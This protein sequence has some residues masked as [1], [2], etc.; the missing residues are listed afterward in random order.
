LQQRLSG[1]VARASRRSKQRAIRTIHRNRHTLLLRLNTMH[2]RVVLVGLCLWLVSCSKIADSGDALVS[3]GGASTSGGMPATGG[4][5]G[6]VTTG[7][8][9]DLSL[10]GGM[11]DGGAPSE[12][13]L[14]RC[15]DCSY[16]ACSDGKTTSISGTVRTPAK[17]DPDPLYNAVVFVPGEELTPFSAGVTCD[18][19]GNVSGK[20]LAA[21][22]SGSDGTFKL[23]DVPAGHDIPLVV[24]MGRWRRQV[25][26]P[27]IVA[28]QDNALPAELTRFPRN[29]T[30]GDIPHM[31]IVTSVYDPEEC[32]LRKI[33]IEDTELTNQSGD[34]R[35]HLFKGMG[36][37]PPL[38][39]G[40]VEADALWGDP[41]ALLRYDMVLLPCGSAPEYVN[42]GRGADPAVAEAARRGLAAYAD[43]GGRVFTTDLSFTWLL[44]NGSPWTKTANWVDD[45]QTDDP[46]PNLDGRVDTTFPKGEALADWLQGI[47]ATTTLGEIGLQET[48]R[49]SLTTNPP[50]QRWLYSDSP[51]TLQ[52]FTFNTPL[53]AAGDK[54]CGR[55]AYSSFHI[56]GGTT[57]GASDFP[58][59]C[60]DAP[61]TPQERVL[62]FMLF[63]LASCVQIDMGKPKPPE[64][65]K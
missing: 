42:G 63:D 57:F 37:T 19:C 34:G 47:G 14:P 38:S 55:T 25:T 48:Y 49:R 13:G 15:K 45:P 28:C 58:D 53:D 4:T 2:T 24:Q 61:L 1:S 44:G 31:A 17:I 52:S 26:I 11:P 21:T 32:I 62:E 46:Q 51:A 41:A 59:E 30:E 64:V 3:S 33:G 60:N 10:G 27:E 22:L 18:R 65:P 12:R 54:Q 9:P 5:T 56:A 43:V 20:P 29:K 16:A 6:A 39:S 7:G 23:D 36:A 35:I 8:G 40:D 50:T